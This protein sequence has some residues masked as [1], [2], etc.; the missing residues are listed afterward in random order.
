MPLL[1]HESFSNL[2]HEY[3]ALQSVLQDE[4]IKSH[5]AVKDWVYLTDLPRHGCVTASGVMWN[6]SRHG[7]GVRFEGE[8]SIIVEIHNHILEKNIVDAYRIS[9]YVASKYEME[10]EPDLFS[11]CEESLKDAERMGVVVKSGFD[12]RIWRLA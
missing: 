8:N 2:L 9:E 1:I 3:V 4:L 5:A 12:Q 11:E 10:D 6:Y 7:L